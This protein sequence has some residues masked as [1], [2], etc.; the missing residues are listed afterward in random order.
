VLLLVPAAW[1]ARTRASYSFGRIGGN[2]APFTVRIA[3]DGSVSSSGPVRPTR[4][5]VGAAALAA[6]ARIVVEQRFFSLP[7]PIRCAGTLPD[8]A[9][10]T[11]TVKLATRERTVVVHGDCSARFRRVYNAL[12]G[13]TGAQ[14]I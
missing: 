2:I 14:K 11:A 13:A 10:N 9:S 12:A 1:S 7:T 6:L 4:R 5:R 3:A 8:V